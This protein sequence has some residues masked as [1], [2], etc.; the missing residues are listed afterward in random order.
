MVK[1]H[2]E[3]FLGGEVWMDTVF[4]PEMLPSHGPLTWYKYAPSST[5]YD[6]LVM[7]LL[8]TRRG[9]DETCR[10]SW[11]FALTGFLLYA[12]TIAYR[13][14]GLFYD[15]NHFSLEYMLSCYEDS[16][17]RVCS[18]KGGDLVAALSMLS[19]RGIITSAQF[20]LVVA[21]DLNVQT[22]SGIEVQFFC[23]SRTWNN[24]CPP[25]GADQQDYSV[26]ATPGRELQGHFRY[27]VPCA[28]CAQ[29]VAPKYYPYKPFV[30]YT[31]GLLHQE[32]VDSVK[33]ELRRVGPLPAA[34]NID[35]DEFDSLV[36]T[37]LL[38]VD[39]P[40]DGMLYRHPKDVPDV[41]HSVLIVGYYDPSELSSTLA[42]R[43]KAFWI[44]R[45]SWGEGGTFGYT[46]RT[47]MEI[48]SSKKGPPLQTQGTV[49]NLF[50]LKMY[51]THAESMKGT[52][53]RV[54]S[55]EEV[56]IKTSPDGGMQRLSSREAE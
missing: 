56:R 8:K 38:V 9:Q 54:L 31:Q 49:E 44:C 42:D 28:P 10:S 17:S 29:P 32:K 47:T 20:P 27:V 36:R 46:L 24:T 55:L 52:V 1:A 14:Q 21:D 40:V 33:S 51:G 15:N 53:N 25:C 37:R 4:T 30:I 19:S 23:D 11:A 18:C 39:D 16:K 43:D 35:R 45:T 13:R 41:Y 26:T 12:T 7:G 22:N 5:F 48:P 3:D 2:C 50:N 34:V 6:Y